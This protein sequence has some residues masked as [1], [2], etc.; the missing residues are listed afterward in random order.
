MANSIQPI[1]P[2][3]AQALTKSDTTTYTSANG[4]LFDGLYV[5]GAGDV[6]VR[7]E[8]GTVVTFSGALAGTT[9]PIK[10]DRLMSTNTTATLILGLRY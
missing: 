7:T 10:F 8:A 1:T 3:D 5:G 2:R 4:G 9:I 6:A